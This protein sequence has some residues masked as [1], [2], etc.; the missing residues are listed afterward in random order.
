MLQKD[1]NSTKIAAKY[2]NPVKFSGFFPKDGQK[3]LTPLNALLIYGQGV[4]P[5][6]DRQSKQLLY[7]GFSALFS[8]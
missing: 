8:G 5:L 4:T 3:P 7:G 1:T 6:A 2:C